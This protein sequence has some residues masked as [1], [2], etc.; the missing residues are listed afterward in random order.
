MDT[1]GQIVELVPTCTLVKADAA[2]LQAH[3]PWLRQRLLEVKATNEYPKVGS[4][5]QVDR[6]ALATSY[7]Q[8]GRCRWTP[9][10]IRWTILR[11]LHGQ[12]TVELFYAVD[13][14]EWYEAQLRG[15][16]VTTCDPDPLVGVPLDFKIWL[17]W[18]D[19]HEVLFDTYRRIDELARERGCTAVE[20]SSPRVG[21]MRRQR[22]YGD[23][24]LKYITWRKDL[25]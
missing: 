3:W 9:E 18:A 24:R 5:R 16:V 11:G 7:G 17:L 10:Q 13:E 2:A 8:S 6:E 4:R 21:W 20:H 23:W 25:I 14:R 22:D 12:T 19:S 1:N 15:F